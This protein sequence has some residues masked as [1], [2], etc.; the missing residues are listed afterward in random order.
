MERE[1]PL[2]SRA[3]KHCYAL[4]QDVFA[5]NVSAAARK[6]CAAKPFNYSTKPF[7][8]DRARR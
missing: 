2:I 7:L 6:G 3:T 1:A 8:D 4:A 5:V